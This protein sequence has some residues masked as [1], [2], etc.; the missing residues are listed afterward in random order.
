MQID[1]PAWRAREIRRL[2]QSEEVFGAKVADSGNIVRFTDVVANE[3]TVASREVWNILYRS[4]FSDNDNG[5]D[6]TRVFG[7]VFSILS[8]NRKQPVACE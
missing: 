5:K 1:Y 6:S 4:V 2:S 3:Q 8:L 7:E